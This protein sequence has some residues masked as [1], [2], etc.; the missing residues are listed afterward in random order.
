[1]VRSSFALLGV[2]ALL[3]T[4]TFAC[5][6]AA[7]PVSSCNKAQQFG[8]CTE[9]R[10]YP[11]EEAK[12]GCG[13]NFMESACHQGTLVGTC[14]KHLGTPDGTERVQVDFYYQPVTPP[15]TPDTLRNLCGSWTWTSGG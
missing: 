13:D 14:E 3:I 6:D 15:H 1:M 7:P 2:P 9:Y 10:G 11:M 8:I 4:G 12:L 5:K